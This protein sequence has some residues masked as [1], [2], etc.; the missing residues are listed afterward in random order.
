MS[1]QEGQTKANPAMAWTIKGMSEERRE[2]V[3]RA[4]HNDQQSVAEYVWQAHSTQ[5]R[6]NR[7][8]WRDPNSQQPPELNAA[9]LEAVLAN[10]IDRAVQ[11]APLVPLMPQWLRAALFR[12]VA[13]QLGIEP[14]HRP[15]KALEGP[16]YD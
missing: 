9:N 5:Q 14:P 7:E 13:G 1:D 3:K 6:A 2:A 12:R 10:P 4:A 15:R 16:K 8:M 11:L